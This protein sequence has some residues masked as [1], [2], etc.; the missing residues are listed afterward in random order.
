MFLP[1]VYSHVRFPVK[2]IYRT[3][4]QVFATLSPIPGFR[5][6]ML[7]KLA[8]SEMTGSAFKEILLRPEEEKALMDAS[9]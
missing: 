3:G 4:L 1:P 6:W 9:R 8:A 7:S 2:L 5:Q